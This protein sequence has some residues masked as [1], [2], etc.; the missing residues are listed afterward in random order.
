MNSYQ[1]YKNV[2]TKYCFTED[3]EIHSEG[4]KNLNSKRKRKEENESI[5][6][7]RHKMKKL[8][9][10]SDVDK[11]DSDSQ[12]LFSE[13]YKVFDKSNP[14]SEYDHCCLGRILRPK[15][16]IQLKHV[17]QVVQ[18]DLEEEVNA[19]SDIKYIAGNAG[20]TRSAFKYS[21]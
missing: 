12:Y 13:Y 14:L 17:K 2:N 1:E 8:K 21:Q 6:Y 18:D 20:I 10:I 16:K 9:G 19:T 5:D 4:S 3:K 7:K 15:K 11:N